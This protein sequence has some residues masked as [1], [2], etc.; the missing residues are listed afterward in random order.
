MS[1][2]LCN[3]KQGPVFVLYPLCHPCYIYLT[4]VID[5]YWCAI[6]ISYVLS[7]I[8]YMYVLNILK[9]IGIHKCLQFLTYMRENHILIIV[10]YLPLVIGTSWYSIQYTP[11][12]FEMFIKCQRFVSYQISHQCLKYLNGH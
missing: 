8:S 11:L 4:L 3:I 12:V 5:A 1:P 9:I 6:Y 7:N 2:V 10:K